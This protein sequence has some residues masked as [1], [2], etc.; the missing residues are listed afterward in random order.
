MKRRLA[1]LVPILALAVI[2]G[3]HTVVGKRRAQGLFQAAEQAAQ[4]GDFLQAHSLLEK[5][6]QLQPGNARAHLLA[7]RA[8]R[9]AQFQEEFLG[10]QPGLPANAEQHLEHCRRLGGPSKI[11][12]WRVCCSACRMA[13]RAAW[14]PRHRPTLQTLADYF[15]RNGNADLAAEYRRRLDLAGP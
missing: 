2:C 12:P 10:P 11:S 4:H 13:S 8:A 9:R 14:N 1:V 6:P 5:S 7:A 15:A 3:G